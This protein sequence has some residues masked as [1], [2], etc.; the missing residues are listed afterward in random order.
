[1]PLVQDDGD[2]PAGC[3]GLRDLAGVP[4]LGRAVRALLRSGRVTR[5]LVPVPPVLLARVGELLAALAAA[6]ALPAA[7]ALTAAAGP[8]AGVEVR[9][10]PVPDHGAGAR[11]LAALALLPDDDEAL[12]VVH[13]PLHPLAP[14]TLVRAV[15]DRL[16]LATGPAV[17]G[18][19]H[20]GPP[21]GGAP[22]AGVVPVRAVTDT[23][24]WVDGD[25]VVTGT[26]DRDGFRTVSS[27]Q[28][29]R[30]AALRA[31]LGAA[32]GAALRAAGAEVLPA[33]VRRA[34]RRLLTVPAPG[35]AFRVTGPE[36]LLLAEAMV[37]PEPEP[38]PEPDREPDRD[39]DPD[40]GRP[41]GGSGAQGIRY[42]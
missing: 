8:A 4:L 1:M 33:L 42:R 25:G 13:D 6:E 10:L 29:Y 7:R 9:V 21:S 32:D 12:V 31:V 41:V 28:A 22:V 19:R 26:A 40:P 17:P 35:E 30:A 39:P 27:P 34:G 36:D 14:A 37:H 20:P 5:V 38:E 15:V 3:A 24:K 23:L 11:L 16:L 2:A 18:A